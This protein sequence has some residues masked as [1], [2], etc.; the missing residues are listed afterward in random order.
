MTESLKVRPQRN[1]MFGLTHDMAGKTVMRVPRSTKIGIGL[2]GG[3]DVELYIDYNGEWVANTPGMKRDGKDVPF[4]RYPDRATMQS[5]W[6]T[7][8]KYAATRKHPKK[9]DY[10]T[11]T[12]PGSLEYDPDWDMIEAHGA[13]PTAIG[14][15]FTDNEPYSGGYQWWSA[16]ELKCYGDGI[17]AMRVL[18]LAEPAERELAAEAAEHLM[19]YF[20]II[21][22]CASC[23]CPY[24]DNPC[25]PVTALKFQ[26]VASPRLGSSAYFH[27]TSK[28]TAQNVA[29]FLDLIRRQTGGYIE[30]I[31]FQ[32]V[33]RSHRVT[34]QTDK[35]KRASTAWNVGL[36]FRADRAVE[37]KHKMLAAAE[38]WRNAAPSAPALAAPEVIDQPDEADVESTADVVELAP[39]AIA[40]EFYPNQPKLPDPPQDETD[41]WDELVSVDDDDETKQL[42]RE[43]LAK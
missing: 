30:G 20:P 21:E 9:I 38:S 32:M 33:L 27:S 37:M 17:N 28:V 26:L 1:V 25:K 29:A 22:G 16:S 34:V 13:R 31:P 14:V 23:G 42:L 2:P 6:P 7:I 5:K 15:M 35:G 24:L 41:G 12:K 36:E 19:E 39:A 11:F 3:K 10:F 40:Q 4:V 8:L 43:E 18:S